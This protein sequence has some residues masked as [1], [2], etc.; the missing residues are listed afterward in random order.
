[1]AAYEEAVTRD[2]TFAIA[3]ARL[4]EARAVG[5]RSAMPGDLIARG[6]EA[7]ERAIR[8]APH[9]PD[10]YRAMSEIVGVTN[11]PKALEL[12]GRAHKLA[13]NDAEVLSL[14]ALAEAK[15]GDEP[16]AL[17]HLARARELDPQSVKVARDAA[18]V[19]LD[20]HRPAEAQR[21]VER[22]LAQDPKSPM[23]LTTKVRAFLAEGDT[24]SARGAAARL[25]SSMEA[26]AAM[27]GLWREPWVLTEEQ[28]RTYLR[29]PA[30]PFGGDRT[31]QASA[32]AILL[33]LRGD[34]SRMRAY[35]DTGLQASEGGLWRDSSQI[36]PPL[37]HASRGMLLGMLG[38]QTEAHAEATAAVRALSDR[39]SRFSAAY[40]KYLAAWT[41]VL[42]GE[43][44]SAITLLEQV[45]AMPFWVTPAYLRVD[46]T[47]APLRDSPRFERLV[48][49]QHQ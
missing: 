5:W 3:W 46:P 28:Q 15:M 13:P 23:L 24:V 4:A 48:G 27:A 30:D 19:L 32:F 47:W 25:G 22:G 42:A 17:D 7:A 37:K 14:V 41:D 38:R 18:G 8:L 29:L 26:G 11:A 6:R 49:T 9:A 10:G 44:E 31:W 43:H 1:M 39:Y 33:R 16:A 2:S 45:V 12:I 34:S 40:F 36:S 21:E 35:A 20:F